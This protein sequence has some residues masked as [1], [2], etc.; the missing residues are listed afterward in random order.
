MRWAKNPTGTGSF[1]AAIRR[2][3]ENV[4]G[5]PHRGIL[6]KRGVHTRTRDIVNSLALDGAAQRENRKGI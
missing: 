6:Y 2:S 3:P 4:D 5:L 1:L